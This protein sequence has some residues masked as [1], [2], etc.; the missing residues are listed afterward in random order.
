MPDFLKLFSNKTKIRIFGT[1]ALQKLYQTNC[2]DTALIIK[3]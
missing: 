1:V 3:L 2:Q